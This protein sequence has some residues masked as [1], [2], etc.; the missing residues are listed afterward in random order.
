MESHAVQHQQRLILRLLEGD[1]D[2]VPLPERKPSSK[3]RAA[4]YQAEIESHFLRHSANLGLH[5]VFV[6]NTDDEEVEVDSWSADLDVDG[7]G[8][9]FTAPN[10][11][12]EM[13]FE[14]KGRPIRPA[15]WVDGSTLIVTVWHT[16]LRTR[17][18]QFKLM[19]QDTSSH[20][21]ITSVTWRGRQFDLVAKPT[22]K[23]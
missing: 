7:S 12:F 17:K 4:T 21:G 14:H 18:R 11:S 3:R 2:A 15:E 9:L 13:C 22:S 23:P 20:S 10:W 8:Q 16:H 5:R 1:W 6:C 19:R